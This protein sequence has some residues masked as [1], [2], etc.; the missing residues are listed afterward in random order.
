[1]IQ[2]QQ[3]QR[4]CKL[5]FFNNY[6]KSKGQKAVFT[7]TLTY[8]AA[9]VDEALCGP[10]QQTNPDTHH[11]ASCYT[12]LL[13]FH[14]TRPA[15][16]GSGLPDRGTKTSRSLLAWLQ[17]SKGHSKC[18]SVIQPTVR[19]LSVLRVYIDTMREGYRATSYVGS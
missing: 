14:T 13:L 4:G 1:M 17:R 8:I 16:A 15:G 19:P 12:A 6:Q 2:R 5:G 11:L 10:K 3:Y 7:M 9:S 18:L